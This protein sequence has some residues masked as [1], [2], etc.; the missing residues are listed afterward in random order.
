MGNPEKGV[1]R[2]ASLLDIRAI[3]RLSAAAGALSPDSPE[4]L[5]SFPPP[6]TTGHHSTTTPPSTQEQPAVLHPTKEAASSYPPPFAARSF[7]AIDL[8]EKISTLTHTGRTNTT[9]VLVCLPALIL[10]YVVYEY[11]A[12]SFPEMGGMWG[13][14]HAILCATCM[15]CIEIAFALTIKLDRGYMIR[16]LVLQWPVTW[17]TFMLISMLAADNRPGPYSAAV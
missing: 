3:R 4:L 12:V 7:T 6:T 9:A 10:I 13:D 17:L 5:L 15:V 2:R 11:V 8:R 1:P 14:H 16:H